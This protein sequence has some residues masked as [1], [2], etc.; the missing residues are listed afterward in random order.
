[1]Q[2]ATQRKRPVV[3]TIVVIVASASALLGLI[4][5]Q[6]VLRGAAMMA[7]RGT[8]APRELVPEMIAGMSLSLLILIAA[9]SLWKG[10]RWGWVASIVLLGLDFLYGVRNSIIGGFDGVS[11]FF[12]LL[13]V[14]FIALLA[15]P[16]ARKYCTR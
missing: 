4:G 3:V 8:P 16:A 12:L 14:V 1:M 15:T 9:P 2:T 5:G 10:F 13:D 6:F 11:V 7:E